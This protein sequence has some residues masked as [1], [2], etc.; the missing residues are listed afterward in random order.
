MEKVEF[1]DEIKEEIKEEKRLERV[2]LTH[3][4]KMLREIGIDDRPREPSNRN[5]EPTVEIIISGTKY[6]EQDD[7][8]TKFKYLGLYHTHLAID[9][10]KIKNK[11]KLWSGVKIKKT[12]NYEIAIN[13]NPGEGGFKTFVDVAVKPRRKSNKKGTSFR[14]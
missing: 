5:M 11:D 1:S 10:E 14:I 8:N 13:M 3:I 9:T 6:K 4:N 12:R 7:N 2:A